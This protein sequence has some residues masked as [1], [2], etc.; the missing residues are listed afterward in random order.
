MHINIAIIDDKLGNRNIIRDKLLRN[1]HF[2]ITL[3]AED[4]KDF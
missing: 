3:T 2:K 4:G 1:A